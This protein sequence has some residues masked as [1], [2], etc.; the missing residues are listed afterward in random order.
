MT[1]QYCG[2]VFVSPEY[3]WNPGA[4]VIPRHKNHEIAC[5]DATEAERADWSGSVPHRWTMKKT[6]YAKERKERGL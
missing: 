3:D 6:R 1:C 4:T 5:R 2:W